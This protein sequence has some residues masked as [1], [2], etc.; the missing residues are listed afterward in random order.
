[1]Q[2]N[3]IKQM[4]ERMIQEVPPE[5]VQDYK[6]D[7]EALKAK[8]GVRYQ[9]EVEPVLIVALASG[10]S[11]IDLL[12]ASFFMGLTIATQEQEREKFNVQFNSATD[13]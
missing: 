10:L 6:K 1:M 13:A 5:Q 7:Y 8:Y 9:E 3:F 11:T 4:Y 12:R 2:P